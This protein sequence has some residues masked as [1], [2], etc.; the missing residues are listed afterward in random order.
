M[1]TSILIGIG[2]GLASALLFLSVTTG[3]PAAVVLFYAAPLPLFIAGFGWGLFPVL[4]AAGVAVVTTVIA[5]HFIFSGIYAVSCAAP[6]VWLVRLALLSRPLDES[7]PQGPREWYPAGRLVLWTAALGACV[8]IAA[9]ITFGG[10]AEN[11]ARTIDTV[12]RELFKVSGNPSPAEANPDV[13]IAIMTR[14]L[15]PVSAALWALF[16]L[17]NMWLAIRIAT[18][19]GQAIRPSIGIRD[20]RFPPQASAAFAA[21]LAGAFVG[22]TL[23]LY[24]KAVLGALVAVFAVLGV[25]VLFGLTRGMAAQPLILA[26]M[27]LLAV[28]MAPLFVAIVALIGIS[29][30]VFNFRNQRGG[31][32]ATPGSE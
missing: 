9:I 13:L 12:F 2:A 32:P 6:C 23:G 8:A 10:T 16:T 25:A 7:D 22:G 30:T 1:N 14:F 19:S 21:A 3:N 29:D 27:V 15:A 11:Y 24:A 28:F 26:A 20:M 18:M 31:P 5:T 17:F 4:V